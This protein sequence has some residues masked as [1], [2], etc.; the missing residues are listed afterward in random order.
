MCLAHGN[1]SP[2]TIL[3][4][5]VRACVWFG[6]PWWLTQGKQLIVVIALATIPSKLVSKG[7]LLSSAA[8]LACEWIWQCPVV[9]CRA[10]VAHSVVGSPLFSEPE[11]ACAGAV[12]P[13]EGLAAC[14][15]GVFDASVSTL[16]HAGCSWRRYCTGSSCGD[17]SSSHPVPR[18]G[19]VGTGCEIVRIPIA[20]GIVRGA[21]SR[22]G[23]ATFPPVAVSAL[24]HNTDI[25]LVSFFVGTR[26]CGH[27]DSLSHGSEVVV[28]LV[29]G[30][31]DFV[32]G[33]VGW[34]V[35]GTSLCIRVP[36]KGMA[37]VLAKGCFQALYCTSSYSG[38][39]SWH[40]ISISSNG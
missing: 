30:K 16:T 1:T 37:T 7:L 34:L 24:G 39:S 2:I 36:V 35:K 21:D 18:S 6:L 13:V 11:L 10:S 26:F 4:G 15:D 19:S 40:I 17:G 28:L 33:T 32:C 14:Y 25:V 22:Q 29:L 8:L 20:Y 27:N 31:N 5:L 3:C 38:G 23:N 9:R 12:V